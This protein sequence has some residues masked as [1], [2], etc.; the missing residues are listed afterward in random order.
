MKPKIFQNRLNLIIV[1]NVF[2]LFL[3]ILKLF[4]IQVI[5]SSNYKDI[6]NDQH[7]RKSTLDAERGVI[8][9]SDKFP[10]ADIEITYLLYVQPK[11]VDDPDKVVQVLFE[12]FDKNLLAS[13]KIKDNEKKL[14]KLILEERYKSRIT[15]DLF[16]VLIKSNI[17]ETVLNQENFLTNSFLF[18]CASVLSFSKASLIALLKLS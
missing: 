6:A 4:S 17:L 7:L 12:T 8:Y 14:Q 11:A 1:F 9:S 16:W 10:L 15:L 13:S 3:I 5:Y 2:A 18:S